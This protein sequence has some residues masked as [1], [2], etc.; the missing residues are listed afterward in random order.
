VLITAYFKRLPYV[1]ETAENG[2]VA[3]EKFTSGH[4]DVVLMDI[5]MPVMDGY[6]AVRTIRAWETEHRRPATPILALTANASA[7]DREA[8]LAAGMDG[9]LVKPLERE[10]LAAALAGADDAALAA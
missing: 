8:C 10:R 3:V 1:V 6:T 5:Q 4:Y 9:F 7:E 2:K